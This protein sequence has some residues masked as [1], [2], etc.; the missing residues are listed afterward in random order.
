MK[1]EKGILVIIAFIV[2]AFS[3][4][5]ASVSFVLSL[6]KDAPFQW[7]SLIVCG[8]SFSVLP[9]MMLYSWYKMEQEQK[10]AKNKMGSLMN[11]F[12]DKE[13]K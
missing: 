6:V 1:L 2:S 4:V 8:S 7:I 5:W 12:P 11:E 13:K 3:G 9:L 10:K